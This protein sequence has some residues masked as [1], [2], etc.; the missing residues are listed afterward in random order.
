MRRVSRSPLYLALCLAW[1][2]PLALAQEPAPVEMLEFRAP[3]SPGA[4]GARVLDVGI[5]MAAPIGWATFVAGNDGRIMMI[6]DGKILYSS[7]KGQTWSEP[8]KT[9]VGVG[10]VIRLNSG[11]LGGIS[12]GHFHV[13]ADDGKTWEQRGSY[14]VGGAAGGPYVNVLMQT[15]SGRIILPV[16]WCG[17]AGHN[18]LYDASMSWGTLNGKLTPVEGHAHYPE[19]DNGHVF[20]SDNEG[21]TWNRS[22]GGILIWHKEGYGGMWPC[23]EPSLIEGRNGDVYLFMRTTLGRLY[24]ARS[25]ASDYVNHA[26]ERHTNAPGER[27]DHPQPTELACSYSPPTMA[28]IPETG[29]WLVI[30][31]QVSGDEMRGSYRRGRLS[32]AISDDDGKTW[33]H[34][35]TIDAVVLP[36][37]GKVEPDPEPQMTRGLDYVGVLP[38]DYG[39]VSYATVSVVGDTAFVIWDRTVVRRRPGDVAG[40]RLRV[41]PLS[42]FYGEEPELTGPAPKL[43]LKVSAHDAKETVNTFEIPAQYYDGRFYVHLA[44][45]AKYLKSPIGRL[46]YNMFAPLHQVITCLGWNPLYDTGHLDDAENPSMTVTCTH[47]HTEARV[48]RRLASAEVEPGS[49]IIMPSEGIPVELYQV[50]V[51]TKKGLTVLCPFEPGEIKKAAL[52]MMV[53]DIDEPKEATILLNGKT[54]IAVD[55]SVLGEGADH[56]GRLTVPS[57][58]LV[59]G[60]NTFEFTFAD[61]L[62]GSTQ[63]YIIMQAS[64]VL[65]VK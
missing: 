41:L 6:G 4:V 13:S 56:Y 52:E 60:K 36:P 20:Y 28:R 57:E 34:F 18:G 45:L 30:F 64:L 24:A 8:E 62:A 40:R 48:P 21:G 25:G 11:L 23:D 55:E 16:R 58:G 63:G 49:V 35:R 17:G 61:N 33:K 1:F 26:G 31:N 27:F 12:G 29:D 44:D 59:K 22:E 65:E 5:E 2:T 39:S 50:P 38:D 10:Y 46:G 19:P 7:D 42:W 54:A 47:P 43:Y 37:T 53:D 14:S 51:G 15:K 32:S 3:A 9:S